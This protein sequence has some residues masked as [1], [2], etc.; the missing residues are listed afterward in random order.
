MKIIME[1]PDEIPMNEYLE[2]LVKISDRNY[3]V[4]LGRLRPVRA[5]TG[6]VIQ[7]FYSPLLDYYIKKGGM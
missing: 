7:I 1:I 6:E 2:R 5:E 3:K 4:L